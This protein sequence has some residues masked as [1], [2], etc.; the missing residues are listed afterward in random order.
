M[1]Y[2]VFFEKMNKISVQF[3]EN[4]LLLI[5]KGTKAKLHSKKCRNQSCKLLKDRLYLVL[6]TM[7]KQLLTLFHG[8]GNS[9]SRL[10]AKRLPNEKYSRAKIRRLSVMHPGLYATDVPTTWMLLMTL[11]VML[12]I[13]KMNDCVL[14]RL[15][16]R[17]CTSINLTCKISHKLL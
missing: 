16:V 7:C 14:R 13:T 17:F 5:H 2:L 10:K 15:K 1:K 3:V 6:S 9:K 4:D 12:H 8:M 11:K